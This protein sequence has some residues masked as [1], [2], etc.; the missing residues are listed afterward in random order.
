MNHRTALMNSLGERDWLAKNFKR[1]LEADPWPDK[2][3]AVDQRSDRK[4]NGDVDGPPAAKRM[5]LSQ[6]GG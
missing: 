3:K 6:V 1:H 4:S 2:D 5:R